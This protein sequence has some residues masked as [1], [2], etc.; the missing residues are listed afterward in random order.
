MRKIKTLF[1]ETT[2]I[3][4]SQTVGEIQ[5]LLG[6]NG[7]S[8]ILVE[9]EKGNIEAVSFCLKVGDKDIPFRLPCRWRAVYNVII[10]RM[11]KHRASRFDEYQAQAK[12]VAWRQILRWIEAQLALIETSMVSAEEVFLPYMTNG[13]G[14]TLFETVKNQQFQLEA[15]KKK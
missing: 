12:R 5:G 1:M 14:Q 9:Y 4:E 10:G 2:K 15:P 6:E 7:A 11:T 8:K 13:E 3:S